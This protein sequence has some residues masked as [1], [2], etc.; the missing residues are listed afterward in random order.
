MGKKRFDYGETA[1][2][3]KKAIRL[4]KPRRKPGTS[5]D[6][7]LGE[8]AA[9]AI[10][11][12]RL[13]RLQ[14]IAD[15]YGTDLASHSDSWRL[16]L[17]LAIEFAPG[18]DPAAGLRK[19]RAPTAARDHL[20]LAKEVETIA[21]EKNCSA[22]HACE[23]LSKRK[24]QWKGK[25]AKTLQAAY[26][27]FQKAVMREREAVDAA[28][29]AMLADGERQREAEATRRRRRNYYEELTSSGLLKDDATE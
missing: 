22:S 9:G 2:S 18:F 8:W 24:G 27:R 26:Y 10:I 1:D 12:E 7:E 23:I 28:I 11:D 5:Q 17:L 15:R 13:R 6:A 21:E 25:G 16:A 14:V 3:A 20:L 19:G 29:G 4:L